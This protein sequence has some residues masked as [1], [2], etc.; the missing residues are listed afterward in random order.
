M[1]HSDEITPLDNTLTTALWEMLKAKD[2][3][4]L[5][6]E[7]TDPQKLWDKKCVLSG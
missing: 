5:C 7:T 6:S 2:P 1:E 3:V 4:K